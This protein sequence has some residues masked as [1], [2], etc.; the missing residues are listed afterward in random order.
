MIAHYRIDTQKGDWAKTQ[1]AN[2]IEVRTSAL[3][4]MCLAD[5]DLAGSPPHA[6]MTTNL[7][8]LHASFLRFQAQHAE[9]GYDEAIISAL[10]ETQ[11]V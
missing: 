2:R 10:R 6:R 8:S 1:P 4:S 3:A 11:S 7:L 5:G 9:S